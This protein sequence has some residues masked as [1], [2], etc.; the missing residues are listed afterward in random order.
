ML[1]NLLNGKLKISIIMKKIL[2]N[3]VFILS[4]IMLQSCDKEFSNPSASLKIDSKIIAPTDGTAVTLN[5]NLFTE[6]AM[7][8]KWS[9]SDFGYSASVIYMLQIVKT[10]DNFDAPQVIP[11]GT[12]NENS[13]TVHETTFSASVLNGKLIAAGTTIGDSGSFKMRVF[14]QPSAQL[15]TSSNG[16]KTY[17]Q[18]VTFTSNTYDPIAETPKIFVVG[19]FG[20]AST[21]ADWDVNLTGTSNSP[22]L[23]SPAKDEK[24]SGFVW[25]NIN[26]PQFKLAN[27]KDTNLNLYGLGGSAGS[28]VNITSLTAPNNITVPYIASQPATSGPGTYYITANLNS[29]SEANKFTIIK[30]RFALRGG[31][32]GNTVKYLDFDSNPASPYYRMYTNTNVSLVQGLMKIQLK[33]GALYSP[34][35]SPDFFGFDNS[36]ALVTSPNVNAQV[37]NKIKVGGGAFTIAA[38]N[39]TVVLDVR[40]SAIYNLRLITN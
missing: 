27:P 9:S 1:F 32:T 12:F 21:Y 7:T 35:S 25:M 28:L 38:G 8:V 17:S 29:A 19:N 30:R 14:G 20:A 10:S 2:L 31:A 24:Y 36:S 37:K 5:A 22:L 4:L 15:A 39:Y 18:E 13:N 16:V 33:D 23:F 40:N 3:T 34:G 26:D 6:P 11:L